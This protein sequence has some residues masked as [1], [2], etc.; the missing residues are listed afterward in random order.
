MVDIENRE[1]RMKENIDKISDM[2]DF[3]IIDCSPSLGIVT[4]V[5]K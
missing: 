5:I 1:K 4:I 3:I 2:Y